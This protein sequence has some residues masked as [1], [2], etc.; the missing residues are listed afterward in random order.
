MTLGG[1]VQGDALVP[2]SGATVKVRELNIT[3]TTNSAG[4]FR[5]D[6]LP[7]RDYVLDATAPGYLAATLVAHPDGTPDKLQFIL[8]QALPDKP[9]QRNQTFDGFFECAAEA[10]IVSGSCDALITAE[11]GPSVFKNESQFSFGVEPGWKTLVIGLSFDKSSMPAMDQMRLVVRPP[12]ASASLGTYEQYGRWSDNKPF[13]ARI[14]PGQSYVE[15]TSPVP[16]NATEFR[17]DVYAQGVGWHEVCY[18]GQPCNAGL[19][20]ATNVSFRVLVSAFYVDSAP[21]GWT[22]PG[23]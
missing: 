17:I 7:V 15:A 5:F 13:V 8:R 22:P 21:A 19:G 16:A 23:L 4:T 20:V 11:G 9:Y 3:E 12:G 6:P 2:I 10:V 14:E 1:V 18:P